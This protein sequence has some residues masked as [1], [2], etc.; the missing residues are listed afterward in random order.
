[1]SLLLSSILLAIMK[2]MSMPKSAAVKF[3]AI[4]IDIA[5]IK[6]SEKV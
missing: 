3:I 6:K 4:D 5:I 2:Y 1:M